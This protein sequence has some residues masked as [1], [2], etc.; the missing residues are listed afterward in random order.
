MIPALVAVLMLGQPELLEPDYP[1]GDGVDVTALAVTQ[2]TATATAVTS[3]QANA[4]AKVS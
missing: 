3:V 2:V 4:T 1:T